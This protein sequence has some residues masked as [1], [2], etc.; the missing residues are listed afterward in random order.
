VQYK[1]K[2]YLYPFLGNSHTD[3]TGQR[4]FTFDGK[5]AQQSRLTE[6]CVVGV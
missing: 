2:F 4:I 5:M 1:S 6:G 3:H